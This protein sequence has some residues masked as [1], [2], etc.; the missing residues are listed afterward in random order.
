MSQRNH[1]CGFEVDFEV[2]LSWRP[3]KVH[4]RAALC[5]AFTG[6]ISNQTYETCNV[7]VLDGWELMSLRSENELILPKR[8]GHVRSF[9]C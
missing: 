3:V 2:I 5:M 4:E 6:H 1:S 8:G 9:Q 7:G